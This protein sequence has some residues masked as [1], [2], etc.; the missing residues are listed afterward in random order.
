MAALRMAAGA[1]AWSSPPAP[2]LAREPN[3]VFAAAHVAGEDRGPDRP[4]RPSSGPVDPRRGGR[5]ARSGSRGTLPVPGE[6]VGKTSRASA[7][8]ASIMSA[9]AVGLIPRAAITLDRYRH[10]LPGNETPGARSARHLS[11][12]DPSDA[13]IVPSTPVRTS[14][15]EL[16]LLLK[17]RGRL[18]EQLTAD[19]GEAVIDRDATA[20]EKQ[21]ASRATGLRPGER[22]GRAAVDRERDRVRVL[23][24]CTGCGRERD[25]EGRRQDEF[26]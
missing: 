17:T 13:W 15:D 9:D 19:L 12:T 3:R 8:R 5:S 2:H 24:R 26:G 25:K 7:K 1:P 22:S 11:T 23:S 6:A 21:R 16:P 14:L 4:M 10:L 18:D 20:P